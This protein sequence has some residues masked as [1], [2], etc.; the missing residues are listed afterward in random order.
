M[1]HSQFRLSPQNRDAAANAAISRHLMRIALLALV[2]S[3][4]AGL[5]IPA[6]GEQVSLQTSVTNVNIDV[7]PVAELQLLDTPLLYMQIPPGGTVL[8]GARVR[9][10]VSGNGSA[11]VSAMPH[12]F[13]QID[14]LDGAYLGMAVRQ[15]DTATVGYD[16]TVRFPS[17]GMGLQSSSLT[18]TENT[19][20]PP[21]SVALNGGTRQGAIDLTANPDWTPAGGI[22]L[23]GLY[24]GEL[25]LTVTPGL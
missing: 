1:T 10:K 17:T 6:H 4:A 16:L 19:G 11:T 7:L 5:P 20:T 21:L 23:P 24:V 2:S 9:F 15:S 3:S 18:G 13:V 14:S 25:I 12:A 22:P 8:P